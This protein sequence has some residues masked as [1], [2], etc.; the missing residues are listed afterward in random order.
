M[1]EGFDV[2]IQYS[3]DC[4]KRLI[5]PQDDLRYV[6]RMEVYA[7]MDTGDSDDCEDDRDYLAEVQ[8]IIQRGDDVESDRIGDDIYQQLRFDLCPE[9]RRKFLKNP[10]VRETAIQFDFS[11]N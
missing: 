3:C 8:E 9:C 1:I 11:E 10:I 4:C 2:M 6:V 5:D 7:A